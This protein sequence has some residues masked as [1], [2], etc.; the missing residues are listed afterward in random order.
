[1]KTAAGIVLA[2]GLAA[3][4]A[5]AVPDRTVT[6]KPSGPSEVSAKTKT[7]PGEPSPEKAVPEE[8][9]FEPGTVPPGYEA[10]AKKLGISRIALYRVQGR[11]VGVT[12]DGCYLLM[13]EE[14]LK[15]DGQ[16]GPSALALLVG[17]EGAVKRVVLLKS[18]DDA[19]C[20]R[21]VAPQLG[22]LEKQA[23]T[24]GE[25]ARPALV[26]P[27]AVATSTAMQKTVNGTLELF[28]PAFRRLSLQ[29]GV[30]SYDGAPLAPD[31]VKAPEPPPAKAAPVPAPE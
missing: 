8:P 27:G 17:A 12:N 28:K 24:T 2:L 22:V 21:L 9:A 15:V 1:M 26:I 30:L 13:T 29:D 6:I 31:A 23:V 16:K 5:L 4:T 18:P 20:V 19:V 10:V 25:E 3:G 7:A 14:Y 11:P